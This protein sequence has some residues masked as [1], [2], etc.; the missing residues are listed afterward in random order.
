[1][2]NYEYRG[3]LFKYKSLLYDEINNYIFLFKI[4]GTDFVNLNY[5]SLGFRTLEVN[6]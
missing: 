1:M 2:N 6:Y 4:C 3:T 5:I